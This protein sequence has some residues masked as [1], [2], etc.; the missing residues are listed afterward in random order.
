MIFLYKKGRQM[1]SVSCEY[2]IKEYTPSLF[3]GFRMKGEKISLKAYLAR[4]YFWLITGVR[5]KFS[6]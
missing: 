6:M 2:D 4:M 1:G 5:R 3:R